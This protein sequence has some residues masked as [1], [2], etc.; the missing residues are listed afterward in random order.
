MGPFR[1]AKRGHPSSTTEVGQP[2]ILT[3]QYE[4]V[5]TVCGYSHHDVSE[6]AE[7]HGWERNEYD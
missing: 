6:Q 3:I 2:D 7:R 1:R 4:E 5:G